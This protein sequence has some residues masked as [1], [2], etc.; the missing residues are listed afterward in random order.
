M[1]RHLD[2]GLAY[3][4]P[5]PTTLVGFERRFGRKKTL[6]VKQIEMI[7]APCEPERLR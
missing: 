1:Q 7:G 3:T 5:Q 6:N 2:R 4:F